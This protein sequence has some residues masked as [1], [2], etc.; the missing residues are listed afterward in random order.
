MKT[1]QNKTTFLVS[2]KKHTFYQ[3]NAEIAAT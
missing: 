3:E 2:L 1:K